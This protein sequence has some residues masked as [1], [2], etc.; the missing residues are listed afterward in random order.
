[1]TESNSSTPKVS[2]VIPTYTRYDKLKECLRSIVEFIDPKQCTVVVVAN[3]AS[4]ETRIVYAEFARLWEGESELLWFDEP[5]GYPKSVNHGIRANDLPFVVLLNDDAEFLA[6]PKNQVIEVMLKPMLEDGAV[7]VTGPLMAYDENTN[8]E[9][10]IFFCVMIRRQCINE[11]GMLDEGFKY[12]GEDTS[13]C[14][15]AERVGWKVVRVPEDHPTELVPLDPART[16]LETWKHDKVH[17][18]NFAIWHDA[19]STIGRLEGC[20]EVLRESRARLKELY[21]SPDD[22]NIH[23]AMVTDGWIAHDE[24]IWLARQAKACG[25]NATIIQIG[26]WHGKSSRAISDNMRESSKLIDVDS[27]NGSS[28]EPDQHATAKEREGDHCYQW[29][30]DNQFEHIMQGKVIPL[31]MLSHNAAH[32]L[33]HRGV[34]ADMIFIDG[35][36]SA[37]GIKTD[38]EA[39]L[40]LLKDGG[41]LCGHDY[42]KENEGPWWVHVRQYVEAEFPNVEK[43]ATSIWHVRPNGSVSNPAIYD[44]LIFNA[45]LDLM[46]VRFAE[47]YDTVDRFV[48]VEA[49]LTHA[50]KPKELHFAANLDRYAKYLDKITHIIVDDFPPDA[51]DAWVRE[52]WQRD[53]IMRG[54]TEC[55]DNDIIILGDAD[56]IPS[57]SAIQSYDPAQGLCRLKQR[58]LYC[59]LNLENPDGWDWQKIAPYKLVREL[60]PCGIRYPPAGHTLI[61]ESGGWHMSF[62]GG[63]DA[64][65]AKLEA[66]AHQEYNDNEYKDAAKA[67][68]R[69][70]AGNDLLGREWLH[71]NR[72]EIDGTFPSYITEH[73]DQFEAAGFIM[74]DEAKSYVET[75]RD[76]FPERFKG[77]KVLEVG[78]LDVN[79][80]PRELFTDCDYTGIDLIEGYGVDAIAAAHSYIRPREFDVVVSTEMLE[81]DEHW[82]Q[83]LKQMFENLKPGG[84]MIVTCAGPKRPEHGTK[85]TEMYSSPATPDYYRN[86]SDEDFMSLLPM[87]LW[88]DAELRYG[89]DGE[90]LYFYGVKV[91]LLKADGGIP[92]SFRRDPLTHQAIVNSVRLASGVEPDMSSLTVTAEISTKDRYVTTLPLT[93]ASI[94]NQTQLPDKLIIYDD[95]EQLDLRDVSPFSGLLRMAD[96]KGVK[97]EIVK[98]PRKGQVAN[99]QHALDCCDTDLIFRIDDDEIAEPNV[100]EVLLSE[101]REGVG[102]V[103]GLVHHPGS[104]GPL[105]AMLDG[106]LNDIALGMN[107]QWFQL[108]QPMD[109]THLY[110]SFLYRRSAMRDAGGYPTELSVVGHRE[111]SIASHSMHRAGWQLIVTPH[112]KTWHLR[113]ASGG[114]RS[115]GNDQS[116]WEHDEAIW[117]Q[118]LATWGVVTPDTRLICCDMGRGDHLLLKG[119]WNDIRRKHPDT[120]YTLAL[121]FPDVFDGVPDINI[122]SIAQARL[123]LGSE[124][125]RHSLYA[126]LWRTNH[127]SSILDGMREFWG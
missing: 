85:A 38:V 17:S 67:T 124:F 28:G 125:D 54:L 37:G 2:I 59:Y 11:T 47:L 18:G 120:R 36:H 86:I 93:I 56:E 79:G 97:W 83:S 115:A 46:D 44:C 109:V 126:Y 100:L 27:Y 62:L 106:S 82:A 60:T 122:I 66:G 88:S 121:C 65:R 77:Q 101:M 39:W 40:P 70:L 78:S 53:A 21:G 89:R 72:V 105:P 23:R 8:H 94:L 42:Y 71:Y 7:G 98:T 116:L 51:A 113:E 90:D 81:H 112:A 35:D 108:K 25:P 6:Q 107:I 26:A 13:F 10:L 29:Y 16:T 41:L 102:A 61:I 1:M 63:P 22:V 69:V 95:G 127:Q 80:T 110:S 103:A 68:E 114:V 43:S 32:T 31:R 50:G 58:L 34:K 5:L 76:K 96:D 117:Q 52:R 55:K 104:V 30:L 64:W 33:A 74:H 12:F 111:E 14:I 87:D 123:I 19:E 73:I 84:L 118:Y 48:V 20:D 99:H 119:I 92:S 15:E 49:N 3:G 4:V 91:S 9:F 45:E 75:V 24:L 57:V